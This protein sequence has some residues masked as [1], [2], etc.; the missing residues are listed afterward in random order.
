MLKERLR[1]NETHRFR[2]DWIYDAACW[3]RAQVGPGCFFGIVEVCP[4]RLRCSIHSFPG[5]RAQVQLVM[6]GFCHVSSTGLSHL[7]VYSGV[8]RK[9]VAAMEFETQL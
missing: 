9:R 2:K 3:C 1:S 7:A 8:A 6:V 4:S 5:V